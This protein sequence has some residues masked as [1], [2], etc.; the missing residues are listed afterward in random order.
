MG[1]VGQ[2]LSYKGAGRKTRPCNLR[3]G[4][5]R[6]PKEEET[7]QIAVIFIKGAPFL[8]DFFSDDKLYV[9]ERKSLNGAKNALK[10][11]VVFLDENPPLE[12]QQTKRG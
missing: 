7:R 11:N 10:S 3:L 12:K 1:Q 8:A 9:R 4:V 6:D 2:G 5:S